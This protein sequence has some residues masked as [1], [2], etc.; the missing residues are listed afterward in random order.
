M[1]NDPTIVGD[2]AWLHANREDIKAGAEEEIMNIMEAS[3]DDYLHGHITDFI[4]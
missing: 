4:L 2:H 1:S 3:I